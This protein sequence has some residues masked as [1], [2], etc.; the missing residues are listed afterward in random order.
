[1]LIEFE[2]SMV[3]EFECYWLIEFETYVC[4]SSLEPDAYRV[5]NFFQ[6]TRTSFF[7]WIDTDSWFFTP[8]QEFH[9][10]TITYGF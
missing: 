1:M 9:N 3:I 2:T 8:S 5:T 10:G 7:L 4:L 6:K